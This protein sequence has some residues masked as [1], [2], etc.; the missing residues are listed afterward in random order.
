M[1]DHPVRPKTA[2][3]EKPFGSVFT[4]PATLPTGR[5]PGAPI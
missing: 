2:A 5:A 3:T 1:K 4:L